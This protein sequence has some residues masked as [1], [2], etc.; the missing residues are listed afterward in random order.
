M[1]V[2]PTK[3]SK[4]KMFTQMASSLEKM[5]DI[6]SNSLFTSFFSMVR[7]KIACKD[8]AKISKKRLFEMNKNMLLIQFK[9]EEELGTGS[10][11][12]ED[13]VTLG[14]EMMREWKNLS[15]IQS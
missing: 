7:V 2:V 6:G 14:M 5:I 15:M 1:R 10:V 9:V 4:W 13:G 11:G 8:A 3:W 12:D